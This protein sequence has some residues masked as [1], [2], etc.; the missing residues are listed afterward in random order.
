MTLFTLPL[1]WKEAVISY[2]F[3]S[4]NNNC[5]QLLVKATVTKWNGRANHE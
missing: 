4:I 5:T 3:I 1:A 2:L